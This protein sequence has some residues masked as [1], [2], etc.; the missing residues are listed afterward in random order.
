MARLVALAAREHAEAGAASWR[1]GW[2]SLAAAGRWPCRSCWAPSAGPGAGPGAGRGGA[3]RAAQHGRWTW[4]RRPG[5]RCWSRLQLAILLVVGRPAGGG[6]PAVPAGR[7]GAGD[8]A[9]SGW[10]CWWCR[11]GAAPPTC[12]ATCAPGPQVIL[13][14]LAAQSATGS[15]GAARRPARRDCSPGWDAAATV[16]LVA[17]VARRRAHAQADEPAR[18][19]RR[20][21]DRHRSRRR[22]LVYPTGDE[23]LRVGDALVL[24]GTEE[25]VQGARAQLAAVPA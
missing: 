1:A 13:E 4:R 21:G 18:P 12:R 2:W 14:A 11:S 9:A 10:C 16:R 15:G 5:G 6:D 17:A 8:P 20:H 7:R 23:T 25:A 19:D 3:A 24:T 22:R